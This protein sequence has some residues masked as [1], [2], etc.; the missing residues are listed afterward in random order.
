VKANE[1]L[2]MGIVDAYFQTDQIF[3]SALREITIGRKEKNCPSA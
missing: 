1:H 2:K 3:T